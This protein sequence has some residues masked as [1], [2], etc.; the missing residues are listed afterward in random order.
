MKKRKRSA[1]PAI[2]LI[3]VA[4]SMS[5]GGSRP[6]SDTGS[7]AT[8]TR[9]ARYFGSESLLG[10]GAAGNE[11]L[12]EYVAAILEG[13]GEEPLV[14]AGPH[15][16]QRVYRL[17]RA[18]S[19][20]EKTIVTLESMKR[21]CVVRRTSLS[22][23]V[24]HSVDARTFEIASYD[25]G[26]PVSISVTYSSEECEMVRSLFEDALSGE[27]FLTNDSALDGVIWSVE[28]VGRRTRWYR[29]FNA[30]TDAPLDS[31]AEFFGLGIAELDK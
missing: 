31:L 22:H 9:G 8:L 1:V 19:F 17:V 30:T 23:F 24:W 18:P 11:F 13:A 20:G 4:M 25:A 5:C 10:S 12:L 15:V 16:E 2:G 26:H 27:R 3:I 7:G 21:R 28:K 14:E 6:D 29:V